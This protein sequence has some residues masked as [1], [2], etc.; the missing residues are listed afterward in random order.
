MA[1]IYCIENDINH[2]KYVGKTSF[3]IEERLKE[4][5]CDYKYE[6][7]KNRP[8]YKA[9][10]K[11]GKE[12][13]H[14]SQLEEC[15]DSLVN[16]REQYWIDKLNTYSCGYNATIGG[17]GNPLYN[18]DAIWDKYQEL[19]CIQ[20]TADFFNCDRRVVRKVV[21]KHGIYNEAQGINKPIVQ[22]TLD[23]DYV[24]TYGSCR[25]AAK[26]L[27]ND[28]GKRNAIS[29]AT[30]SYFRTAFGYRWRLLEDYENNVIPLDGNEKEYQILKYD[31]NNNLL[32]IYFSITDLLKHENISNSALFRA[33]RDELNNG[34]VSKGYKWIKV[35]G[36]NMIFDDSIKIKKNH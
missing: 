15:E 16:E 34:H 31:L 28:A 17:D 25:E 23:N 21:N 12:H 6:R 22:L 4:H 30:Q 10:N 13:F 35:D 24:A 33:V 14:I 11:Y 3:T 5:T 7:E 27:Y 32:T 20:K 36:S 26:K 1:F 19:K 29:V 18:H 8:L 9:I 2:K